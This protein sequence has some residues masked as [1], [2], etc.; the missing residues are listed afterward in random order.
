M[1]N[2]QPKYRP[3]EFPHNNFPLPT[4]TETV[5]KNAISKIPL[6]MLSVIIVVLLIYS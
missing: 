2:G 3:G 1:M 4:F 5:G 6:Q